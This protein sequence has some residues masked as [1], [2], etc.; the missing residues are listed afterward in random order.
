MSIVIPVLFILC[1]RTDICTLQNI[2]HLK[3]KYPT[4]L[5]R[6]LGFLSKY[7]WPNMLW[8]PRFLVIWDELDK[9]RGPCLSQASSGP[10]IALFE[11]GKTLVSYITREEF[12][13]DSLVI[14]Y[15]PIFSARVYC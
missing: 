3:L 1:F 8:L 9:L 5:I 12:T 6:S 13:F 2:L 10:D 14:V 15:H 11:M 4:S 7:R